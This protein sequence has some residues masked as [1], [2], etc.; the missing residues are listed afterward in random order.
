MEGGFK[1]HEKRKIRGIIFK[2][3]KSMKNAVRIVAVTQVILLLLVSFVFVRTTS[4]PPLTWNIEIVDPKFAGHNSIAVDGN[5]NPHIAYVEL[6][7]GDQDLKYAVKSGMGW[8]LEIVDSEGK[9][10][11]MPSIAVDSNGNPH[12]SYSKSVTIKYATKIGPIWLN[13]TISTSAFVSS[14]TTDANDVPHVSYFWDNSTSEMRE[15]KYAVKSGIGWIIETVDPYIDELST[16]EGGV[17]I[18]LDSN[19]EPH[20]GYLANFTVKY[21]TKSGG[22]WSIETLDTGAY[23]VHT[24]IALDA[25]DNPHIG[26]WNESNWDLKY[27]V[28]VGASWTMETVESLFGGF[29]CVVWCRVCY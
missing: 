21:A 28:K 18:K 9:F 2:R 14:I 19:G 20:I 27:A 13:E 7:S 23:N 1:I 29:F 3:K 26:Y 22:S 4:S 6:K 17:S 15:L 10:Y 11:S 12:I 25:G 24:S 8:S 5:N 16:G